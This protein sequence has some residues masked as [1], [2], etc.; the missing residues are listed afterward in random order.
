MPFKMTPVSYFIFLG[1]K[2]DIKRF[3]RWPLNK[4]CSGVAAAA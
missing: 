1:A 4:D 2:I 3:S